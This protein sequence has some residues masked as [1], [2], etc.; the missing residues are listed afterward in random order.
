MAELRDGRVLRRFAP[1]LERGQRI[2]GRPRLN[3]RPLPLRG[4][5][6]DSHLGPHLEE[7]EKEGGEEEAAAGE[8][9]EEDEEGDEGEDG[10]EGEE[11]DK[12][13]AAEA[14]EAEEEEAQGTTCSSRLEH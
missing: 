11:E 8:E 5:H 10:G 4:S 1:R 12:E 2:R 14:E 7:E 9:E 13:E 6:P 3:R